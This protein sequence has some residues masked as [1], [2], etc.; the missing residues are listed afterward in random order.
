M[1]VRDIIH[2]EPRESKEKVPQRSR[3]SG[4]GKN[5]AE[6]RAS[7][8]LP[9]TGQSPQVVGSATT[10]NA[11]KRVGACVM[12]MRAGIGG[13]AYPSKITYK[14]SLI[15]KYVYSKVRF[16]CLSLACCACVSP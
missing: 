10:K 1:K 11:P 15:T 16:A 3:A 8:M 12:V 14:M 7:L 2:K 6:I 9:T 5:L 4:S 13:A